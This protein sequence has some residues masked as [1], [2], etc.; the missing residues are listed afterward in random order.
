MGWR[1]VD[2]GG[3]Q[4]LSGLVHH[5]DFTSGAVGRVQP[6]RDLSLH[7]GLHQQLAQVQGKDVDGLLCG[8]LAETRAKLPLQ[9]RVD[10]PVVGVLCRFGEDLEIAFAASQMAQ[11]QRQR[12]LRIHLH[13]NLQ[14]SFPLSPV[15][16]QDPMAGN[17]GD[18]FAV[19]GV[20]LIYI[21]LLLMAGSGGEVIALFGGGGSGDDCP[22]LFIELA[23]DASELCV[24]RDGFRHNI[25]GAGK[26]L[27]GAFHLLFLREEPIRQFQQ[28]LPGILL[29]PDPLCQR[30]KPLFPSHR[31]AGAP[32]GT[33][34][35]IQILQGGQCLGLFQRLTEGVGKF[36]LAFDLLAN[37]LT[38]L[39]HPP[40]IGEPLKKGAQRLIV[41][42]A[43][44]F[45]AVAGDKRDGGAF[46]DQ[47]D[48]GADAGFGKVKFL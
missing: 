42:G 14:Q 34:G 29:F 7:R 18:G 9:R 4:H 22:V 31:G 25:H 26:G 38:T 20:H 1:G 10:Q 36:S 30:G 39:F 33:V 21:R 6:Q 8:A 43:G 41:H 23:Q 28:L 24:V 44:G 40:Q 3:F 35:Q 46:V 37:F 5:G 47:C 48:G 12:P 32:L 19:I 27:L 16:R 11:R 13:R 15:Q 17:F 2:D 45:L